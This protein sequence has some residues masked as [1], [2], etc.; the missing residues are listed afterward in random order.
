VVSS[1][2]PHTVAPPPPPVDYAR[3]PKIV[4]ALTPPAPVVAALPAKKSAPAVTPATTEKPEP[5][6]RLVEMFTDQ[7]RR[8]VFIGLLAI[9]LIGAMSSVYH[10][11]LGDKAP[12]SQIEVVAENLNVHSGPGPRYTTVGAVAKGT[13]HRV[14]TTVE[15]GWMQIE[16]SAWS[17]AAPRVSDQNQGWIY[18]SP[19]YV[20][21]V[22]RRWW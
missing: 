10:Y 3:P 20:S 2:G 6:P 8:R 14:L 4:V 7:V 16:V 21:I 22:A 18:G 19:E 1:T 12:P 13:H 11:A 17:E 5:K 9:A 15:N